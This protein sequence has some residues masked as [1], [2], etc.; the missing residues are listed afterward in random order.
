MLRLRYCR[1]VSS[2]S[3]SYESGISDTPLLGL[4]VCQALDEAAR[5]WPSQT[6]LISRSHNVE[7]TYEELCDRA[8]K[9]STGLLKLGLE[10]GSRIGAWSLNRPEWLLTQ[11]AAAKAG[12]ILVTVN[13]AYR[14]GKII[15]FYYT[16]PSHVS[17]LSHYR[18]RATA[19]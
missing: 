16:E 4:T 9:L 19:S 17:H 15:P 14:A 18:I 13:P 2:A 1:S 11:F 6:A 3:L 7:W 10:P 8:D 12:L 5:R